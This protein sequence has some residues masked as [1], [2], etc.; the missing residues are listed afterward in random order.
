MT[1]YRFVTGVVGNWKEAGR[2]T[3]GSAADEI[4]VT[5]LAADRYYQ[6][7]YHLI[8]SGEITDDM[9]MGNTTFSTGTVYSQTFSRDGAADT[10]EASQTSLDVGSPASSNDKFGTGFICNFSSREK[11]LVNYGG[12]DRNTAGAANPPNRMMSGGKF[13]FTSNPID[14]IR[15]TNNGAGS[16]DTNSELVILEWDPA[17]THGV[18]DNAWEQLDQ[19]TLGVAGDNI[20]FQDVPV[21]KYYWLWCYAENAGSIRPQMRFN[22]NSSTVYA[23]RRALNSGADV[24]QGSR[25]SILPDIT[26]I[27]SP[28][29]LNMFIINVS[30][31]EKLI[32][33]HTETQNTAGAINAPSRTDFSSKM[34]LTSS[35]INDILIFQNE[36]GSFGTNTIATLWGFD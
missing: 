10:A 29:Q 17:D 13:D 34:A 24:T 26:V 16:Y 8:P 28:V 32:I 33:G 25:S 18:A 21:R 36:S 14:R 5:G 31:R 9:Q 6:Y 23:D 15:M 22:N 4:E 12:I 30:G 27:T 2:T 3:L 7:L 11:Y 20:D 1:P 19:V 35:A